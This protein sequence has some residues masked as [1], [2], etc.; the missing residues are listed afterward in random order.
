MSFGESDDI[1]FEIEDVNSIEGNKP[2]ES[3]IADPVLTDNPCASA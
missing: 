1:I 3:P 2:N